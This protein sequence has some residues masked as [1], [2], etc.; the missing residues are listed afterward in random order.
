MDHGQTEHICDSENE[1]SGLCI[2]EQGVS[3]GLAGCYPN[4][5][6]YRARTGQDRGGEHPEGQEEVRSAVGVWL[7]FQAG[8]VI[9]GHA[10]FYAQTIPLTSRESSRAGGTLSPVPHA[11]PSLIRPDVRIKTPAEQEANGCPQI[12]APGSHILFFR[13]HLRIKNDHHVHNVMFVEVE[14][15]A[16]FVPRPSSHRADS[17]VAL[18]RHR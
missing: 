14:L 18:V 7:R 3:H 15:N 1:R 16:L 13:T 9:A 10:V 17:R 12:A 4:E 6:Q 5:Q 8:R 11:A 2:T